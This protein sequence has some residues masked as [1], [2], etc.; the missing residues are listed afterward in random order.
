MSISRE[1]FNSSMNN[2]IW[3]RSHVSFH[4]SALLD[5]PFSLWW[6]VFSCLMSASLSSAPLFSSSSPSLSFSSSA[7]SMTAPR[8]FLNPE[9]TNDLLK[10]LIISFISIDTWRECWIST[11]V[12]ASHHYP[13]QWREEFNIPCNTNTFDKTDKSTMI[14]QTIDETNSSSP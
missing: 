8:C 9:G 12:Q 13:D 10:E 7:I 11:T 5:K 1:H 2:F 3:S 6:Q 14:I 4:Y